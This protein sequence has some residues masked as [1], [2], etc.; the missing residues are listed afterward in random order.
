VE[1]AAVVL[2]SG[3][4]REEIIK[5]EHIIEKGMIATYESLPPWKGSG[6]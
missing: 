2:K 3:V 6:G 4:A 1:K 5:T